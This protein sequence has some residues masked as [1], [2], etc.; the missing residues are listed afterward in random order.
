MRALVGSGAVFLGTVAGGERCGAVW[1][2]LASKRVRFC[3]GQMYDD[4]PNRQIKARHEIHGHHGHP[5]AERE[6]PEPGPL[7][8]RAKKGRKACKRSILS[9]GKEVDTP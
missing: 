1:S 9:F 3:Q 8:V 7:R 5:A 2:V 4:L 6:P